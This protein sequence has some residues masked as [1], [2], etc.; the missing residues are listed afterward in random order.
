MGGTVKKITM[1]D[2]DGNFDKSEEY[3]YHANSNT[4]ELIIRYSYGSWTVHEYHEN[5]CS[6]NTTS[7]YPNG[8]IESTIEFDENGWPL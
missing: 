4:K 5:G 3:T 2:D 6:K 7:Y 8:E 1:V